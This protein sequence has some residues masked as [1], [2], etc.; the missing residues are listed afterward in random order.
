MY[1]HASQTPT[2]LGAANAPLVL[3]RFARLAITADGVDKL[4]QDDLML[5]P[6]R[7]LSESSL[8]GG[9]SAND[10]AAEKP[11]LLESGQPLT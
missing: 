10:V 6:N 5:P 3:A 1:T 9:Q 11:I 7:L 8:P 4:G 2:R